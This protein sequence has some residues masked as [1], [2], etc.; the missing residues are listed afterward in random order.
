MKRSTCLSAILVA[1][2]VPSIASAAPTQ[3]QAPKLVAQAATNVGSDV[4][5]QADGT[6]TG[7][8]TPSTGTADGATAGA[9]Q[10]AV[11]IGTSPTA[12]ATDTPQTA[13]EEPK[14]TQRQQ[15]VGKNRAKKKGK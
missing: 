2:S 11:S 7:T 9:T 8:G 12:P 14:K 5:Q 3:N 10:P 1:L 4:A 6:G 15:P 13:P